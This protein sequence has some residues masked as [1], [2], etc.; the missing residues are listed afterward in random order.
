MGIRSAFVKFHLREYFLSRKYSII[1][2]ADVDALGGHEKLQRGDTQTKATDFAGGQSGQSGQGTAQPI[3]KRRRKRKRNGK[4]TRMVTSMDSYL[5]MRRDTHDTDD[6]DADSDL[7][8]DD[9]DIEEPT[10]EFTVSATGSIN[11]TNTN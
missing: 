6:E 11:A 9:E 10:V 1:S 2:V 3:Q 8:T 4:K 5:K 7:S